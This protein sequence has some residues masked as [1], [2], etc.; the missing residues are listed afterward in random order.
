MNA[1]LTATA[2]LKVYS[3]LSEL[4]TSDI[5][6]DAVLKQSM[7]HIAELAGAERAAIFLL[8]NDSTMNM[9]EAFNLDPRIMIVNNLNR[10]INYGEEAF[11][12]AAAYRQRVV[13]SDTTT[14]LFS[15]LGSTLVNIQFESAAIFP[16][17]YR[18]K[19][20]G[21]LA[22]FFHDKHEFQRMELELFESAAHFI[23]ISLNNARGYRELKEQKKK[24][25]ALFNQAN[26]AILIL[27]SD[28]YIK[29]ANGQFTDLSGYTD[30]ELRERTI[31]DI[32]ENEYS[33]FKEFYEKHVQEREKQEHAAFI[34]TR[35]GKT[36]AVAAKTSIIRGEGDFE[37]IQIIV[38]DITD[39]IQA[40][41]SLLLFKQYV[42]KTGQIKVA[43]FK[44]TL[45]G[46]EIL[47]TE[48]LDFANKPGDLLLNLSIYYMTAIGQGDAYAEGLFDLPVRDHAEMASLV[49]AF[50]APDRELDDPRF[51][52]INYCLLS[53][54][55]PHELD[56]FFS[57]RN[58]I[59]FRLKNLVSGLEDINDIDEEFLE[60]VKRELLELDGEQ[61]EQ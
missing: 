53:L 33:N 24:Y 35:D 17:I 10:A 11:G 45:M 29:G 55:F 6:L 18:E 32:M 38:K 16:V 42:L 37:L 22:L 26:D 51:G 13:I 15:F 5:P 44:N 61:G 4:T 20:L 47:L 56:D 27:S 58:S 12:L 34:R 39:Q 57:D 1:K 52:G 31:I 3:L 19:C 41:R 28:G 50:R 21:V 48:T 7:G 36:V 30:E 49:F 23:A 54:F 43:V 40:A 46:P 2:V 60:R 8:G 59:E 14:S 25:Q 9:I